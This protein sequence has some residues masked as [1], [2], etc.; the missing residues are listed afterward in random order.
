MR[1]A[2]RLLD[3]LFVCLPDSVG[4]VSIVFG[5]AA[6]TEMPH[7][8]SLYSPTTPILGSGSPSRLSY[9]WQ[10][11]KPLVRSSS[12]PLARC[13]ASFTTSRIT[14]SAKSADMDLDLTRSREE[15][16]KKLTRAGTSMFGT[17]WTAPHR[18]SS[19][20]LLK[21]G[22]FSDLVIKCD[23][24]T[25][26]VHR[27]IL[28]TVSSFFRTCMV[29]NFKEAHTGKIDLHDTTA[30]AV[31]QMLVMVYD[32]DNGKN[33]DV[34]YQIWPKLRTTQS[35]KVCVHVVNT[36]AEAESCE[37][38]KCQNQHQSHSHS[39]VSTDLCS[40]VESILSLD[41]HFRLEILNLVRVYALADR[42]ML[43]EVA[44]S[45]A[46]CLIHWF[47]EHAHTA[48]EGS[49]SCADV[50]DVR[51]VLEEMYHLTSEDDRRLRRKAT[52]VC[53]EHKGKLDSIAG[54]M[55]VIQQNESYAMEVA[56]QLA[57]A[58]RERVLQ[59]R[60]TLCSG[61]HPS[62]DWKEYAL[63]S[64]GSGSRKSKICKCGLGFKR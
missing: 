36:D 46:G 43:D 11:F 18:E 49:Y 35:L 47:G 37:N 40:P 16:D 24:F 4:R 17:S 31:A 12:E 57:N 52:S 9:R 23:G 38:N 14:C 64:P 39:G 59:A 15:R 42:L 6:G 3:F 27:A 34:V 21:S 45:V 10:S 48:T 51:Y 53:L 61:I 63:S 56:L 2:Q 44:E 20:D 25:F 1:T 54:V 41:A 60:C 50:K 22:Y 32:G 26:S 8:R 30:L 62:M 13:L 58:L 19:I 33:L 28:F 55:D 5:S 29:G 7:E